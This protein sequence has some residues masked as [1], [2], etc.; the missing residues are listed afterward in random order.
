MTSTPAWMVI[1]LKSLLSEEKTVQIRFWPNSNVTQPGL[2][3]DDIRFA[4]WAP[5]VIT[6]KRE[7][8][9]SSLTFL[10]QGRT[11]PYILFFLSL[12]GTLYFFAFFLFYTLSPNLFAAL[13]FIFLFW[14]HPFLF[15]F[16]PVVL[17]P[18]K[19]IPPFFLFQLTPLLCVWFSFPT[20]RAPS[21]L[22][23]QKKK[24]ITH[25]HTL[26]IFVAFLPIRITFVI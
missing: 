16:S 6:Y 24:K 26:H 11:Y 10:L 25:I 19:A 20:L 21:A 9:S 15:C 22:L 18:F 17:C 23:V 4:K 1:K 14:F 7:K 13:F 8:N 5:D 12:N 3:D 2:Y